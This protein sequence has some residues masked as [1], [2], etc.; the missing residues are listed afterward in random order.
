M[1][2]TNVPIDVLFLGIGIAKILLL[3]YPVSCYPTYPHT[4]GTFTTTS[5]RQLGRS[6]LHHFIKQ[7]FRSYELRL[8]KLQFSN[9][10]NHEESKDDTNHDGIIQGVSISPIGFIVLLQSTTREDNYEKRMIL[11]IRVTSDPEDEFSA[12]SPE[13][14]T[15]C[16][17]LEGVDM[18]GAM[19]KPSI[20]NE[21]VALSCSLSENQPMQSSF[22]INSSSSPRI[23]VED[24]LGLSTLD[25]M[26]I[27]QSSLTSSTISS[28]T[29]TWFNQRIA[30]SLPLQTSFATAQPWER[31][32]VIFPPIQLVG[33]DIQLP[34]DKLS[35]SP[36][37][38]KENNN[39]NYTIPL[40]FN[41]KCIV[42]EN[43]PL[44]V[45]LY[46]EVSTL[47]ACVPCYDEALENELI[48]S[49]L[50]L[51]Q[52]LYT[53]D[54]SSSAAY[55]AIA[56]ALRYD[57]PI[58]ISSNAIQLFSLNHHMEKN[59][60][61][62]S[63]SACTNNNDSNKDD[64]ILKIFP[65]FKSRS[66]VR[67]MMGRTLKDIEQGFHLKQLMSALNVAK[68]KKDRLAITKIELEIRR[69]RDAN[70]IEDAL[71]DGDFDGGILG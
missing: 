45:P 61:S 41:L 54:I 47:K 50:I 62:S 33:V 15:I 57:A 43:Q 65:K 58:R 9:Q 6:S 7:R 26:Q 22:L 39:Y 21:V 11:P 37:L 56:L 31:N 27:Q 2:I 40:Q 5:P 28:N 13:S 18:A 24:E 70:M 25:N 38:H 17:L 12:S 4:A 42:N 8:D 20:L 60:S 3:K 30:E 55:L 36:Q 71:E 68:T 64:E 23:H 19:L 67:T 14:L 35:L 59:P 46:S 32:R 16:Q 48:Q 51:R 49:E 44:T 10:F 52:C 1:H 53:F 29:R 63:S 69:I 34:L 66:S